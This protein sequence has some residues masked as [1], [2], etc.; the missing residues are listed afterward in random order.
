[1]IINIEDLNVYAED[2]TYKYLS[3]NGTGIT[4]YFRFNKATNQLTYEWWGYSD[5]K[6]GWPLL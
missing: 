6:D 5:E 4:Q 3:C 1:M 2:N